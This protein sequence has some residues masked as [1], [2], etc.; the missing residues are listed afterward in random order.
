MIESPGQRIV[1]E[2]IED[3]PPFENRLEDQRRLASLIDALVKRERQVAL[4]DAA[5]HVPE[6]DIRGMVLDRLTR[7]TIREWLRARAAEEEAE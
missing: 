6:K 3:S 2:W 7:A 4:R 1:R 5:H